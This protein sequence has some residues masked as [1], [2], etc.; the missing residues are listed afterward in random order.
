MIDFQTRNV[1]AGEEPIVY[2]WFWMR[3]HRPVILLQQIEPGIYQAADLSGDGFWR[4]RIVKFY[5]LLSCSWSEYLTRKADK[6]NAAAAKKQAARLRAKERIH[7]GVA[8]FYRYKKRSQ[9][10]GRSFD[11]D[12]ETFLATIKLPCH[13]CG[14]EQQ[15]GLDRI[16]SKIGYETGNVLP[17]CKACNMAKNNMSYKEFA[18]FIQKVGSHWARHQVP[19]ES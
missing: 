3:I 11:L 16:D 6:E 15:I 7:N 18:L 10:K 19:D 2:T 14:A 1:F 17:C 13:Y 4:P 12:K 9:V 5:A 8:K